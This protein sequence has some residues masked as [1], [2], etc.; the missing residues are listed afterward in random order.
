ML[1]VSG[2]LDVFVRPASKPTMVG[3]NFIVDVSWAFLVQGPCVW[4]CTGLWFAQFKNHVCGVRRTWC[5]PATL[6]FL[7][8]TCPTC[9]CSLRS[10]QATL[11]RECQSRH[12]VAD[13]PLAEEW[14]IMQHWLKQV[15]PPDKDGD[16][17]RT[18]CRHQMTRNC[19][20]WKSSKHHHQQKKKHR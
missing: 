6:H 12:M 7:T 4:F 14:H 17:P 18:K 8:V 9:S 5:L 2:S 1:V 10:T 16:A 3:M 19:H 20:G 13:I 11:A 15:C